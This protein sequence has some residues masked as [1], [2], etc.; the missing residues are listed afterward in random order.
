MNFTRRLSAII[1]RVL[2]VGFIAAALA[3]ISTPA[4]AYLDPGTAGMLLQLLLGGVAGGLVVFK[5]YWHKLVGAVGFKRDAV[6]R[7]REVGTD[8]RADS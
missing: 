3:S 2:S 7:E 6:E 5:L 1:S 8:G 4:Y